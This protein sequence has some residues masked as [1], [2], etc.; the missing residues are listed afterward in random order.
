MVASH[1][2]VNG[3]RTFALLFYN[4]HY[5]GMTQWLFAIGKWYTIRFS[6]HIECAAMP[7]GEVY[8][9]P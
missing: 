8:P 4:P 6:T 5:F 9:L 1:A 3:S 7:I 2:L